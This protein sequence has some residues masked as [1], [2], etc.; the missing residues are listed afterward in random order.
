MPSSA[1]PKKGGYTHCSSRQQ[2]LNTSV[3]TS[4]SSWGECIQTDWADEQADTSWS[5]ITFSSSSSILFHDTYT[6]YWVCKD[7]NQGRKV[8]RNTAKAVNCKHTTAKSRVPDQNGVSQA[9]YIVQIHHSGWK[10]SKWVTNAY[11]PPYNM[12]WPAHRRLHTDIPV[13]HNMMEIMSANDCFIK[14]READILI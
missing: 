3:Q 13:Q 2:A 1:S 9:W 6:K 12:L 11:I 10:P 5:M 14:K 7:R 8:G 4:S